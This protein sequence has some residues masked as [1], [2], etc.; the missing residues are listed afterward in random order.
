MIQIYSDGSCIPNPGKGGWAWLSTC[1]KRASGAEAPSTNQRMEI[2]AVIEALKAFPTGDV[3]IYT[4]SQF[5]INGATKWIRS[6]ITRNWMT[7]EKTPVKNRDLWE[8][9]WALIGER[10][11]RFEWVRGHNGNPMNEQ[12]DALANAATGASSE[13]RADMN[14]RITAQKSWRGRR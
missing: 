2:R 6:W 5:V 11:V 9:L 3:T 4:D 7:K 13:D 10:V 14:R 1:G 8:E 12:V